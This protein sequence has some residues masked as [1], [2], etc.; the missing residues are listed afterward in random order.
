M[1]SL[2]KEDVRRRGVVWEKQKE[3]IDK[4][5]EIFTSMASRVEVLTTP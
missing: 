4:F 2:T 1:F 3:N 5:S